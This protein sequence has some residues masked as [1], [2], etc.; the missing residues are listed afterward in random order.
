LGADFI[1][2]LNNDALVD[3]NCLNVLVTFAQN[4]PSAAII[5]PKIYYLDRPDR[6]WF[7]GANR[8]LPTLTLLDFGRGKK[9]RPELNFLREV[10]YLCAGAMLVR[11]EVFEQ[12]GGF[13]PGYFMYYEDCE[14]CM[15]A[16]SVGH[17]LFFVPD[18]KVW[19]AVAASTGGE[20]SLLETYYRTCS[21]FRFIA[22]NSTGF[23]KFSLLSLRIVYIT[24][25]ILRSLLIGKVLV[26]QAL[27]EGLYEG[28]SSIRSGYALTSYRGNRILR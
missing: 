8:N 23:H 5:G 6:I 22:R 18:A 25:R 24:L 1:L 14:F 4:E 19:H 3:P 26:A 10:T 12:L 7:A 16:I 15:R 17:T 21:V 9:D 20:G 11:R 28:L 2:T 27:Y 13:D